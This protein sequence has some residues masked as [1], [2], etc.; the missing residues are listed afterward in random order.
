VATAVRVT[1]TGPFGA[2]VGRLLG[3]HLPATVV[4]VD[5]MSE[6]F[7]E[8]SV[9]AVLALWRPS[10]ALCER[11]D[12]LAAERG[13]AWLP[14]VLEHPHLR[15]GPL[16]RPGAGP[17]FR[18]YRVRREQHDEHR[19]MTA[20]LQD[21][22]DGRPELGPA[23]FLPHHAR[24]ASTLVMSFVDTGTTGSVSSVHLSTGALVTNTVVACHGCAR[25]RPQRSLHGNRLI[26]SSLARGVS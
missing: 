19:R 11:A 6:C 14:A 18:C 7:L 3:E 17:C 10:M 9:Y 21:A 25:C 20:A 15:V 16:I 13:V 24:W 2:A 26:L 8:P 12:A 23:G 22:Y 5:G 4:G 1:G